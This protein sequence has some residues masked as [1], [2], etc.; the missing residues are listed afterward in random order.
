M[1][2]IKSLFLGAVAAT[3]LLVATVYGQNALAPLGNTSLHLGGALITAIPTG[4]PP[5]TVWL[6]GA[7]GSVFLIP[8]GP[9]NAAF[10][11]I[12]TNIQSGQQGLVIVNNTST[13]N[14]KVTFN[15]LTVGGTAVDHWVSTNNTLVL[16]LTTDGATF[17][18]RRIHGRG[19]GVYLATNTVAQWPTNAESFGGSWLGMSNHVVYL[20]T[21]TP[22]SKAWG[23]TNKIAP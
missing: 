5:S 17:Y 4:G 2:S 15:D 8:T 21:T 18:G 19:E 7:K 20:L 9:T 10:T 14:T 23:A 3:A 16:E 13:N 22:G 6:D 1:T 11:L 12:T